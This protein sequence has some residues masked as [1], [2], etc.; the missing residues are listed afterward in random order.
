MCRRAVVTMTMMSW[1]QLWI[2]WCTR[3]AHDC[4]LQ[5]SGFGNYNYGAVKKNINWTRTFRDQRPEVAASSIYVP[6]RYTHT[7]AEFIVRFALDAICEW[8]RIGCILFN[9]CHKMHRIISNWLKLISHHIHDASCS[10]QK[11]AFYRKAL[12][13]AR[14]ISFLCISISLSTKL[15]TNLMVYCSTL[16]PILS[17]MQA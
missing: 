6:A 9:F 4:P 7:H 16:C 13:F 1:L 3:S 2:C 12:F 10:E 11:T 14:F 8:M 17:W 15:P 5:S